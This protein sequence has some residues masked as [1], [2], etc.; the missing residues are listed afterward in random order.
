LKD[1][2]EQLRRD[3]EA[4]FGKKFAP[5]EEGSEDAPNQPQKTPEE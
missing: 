1:I 4:R 3:K 5:G 2:K